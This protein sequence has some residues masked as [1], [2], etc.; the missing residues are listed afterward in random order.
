MGVVAAQ[1]RMSNDL[2]KN[3][4]IHN[5]NEL[6]FAQTTAV[7]IPKNTHVVVII[8]WKLIWQR[9]VASLAAQEHTLNVPYLLTTGLRFD[10]E[11]VDV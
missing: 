5:E 10:K 9:G 1:A 6:V 3:H 7:S 8:H 11:T 2:R 4:S